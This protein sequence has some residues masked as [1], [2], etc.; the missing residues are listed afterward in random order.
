MWSKLKG[1]LKKVKARTLDTLLDAISEGLD[2]ISKDDI[3]GW[4]EHSG[5]SIPQ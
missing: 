5:Y 3:A 2:L 4:F 1:H